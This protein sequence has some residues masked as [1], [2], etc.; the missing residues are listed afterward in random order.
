MTDG[1]P[2]TEPRRALGRGG[3]PPWWTGSASGLAWPSSLVVAVIQQ[4]GT[5]AAAQNQIGH[6]VELDLLARL[7]LLCGPAFL[8]VR[9]R[10]PRLALCG[11]A[12][13]LMV[14]LAGGYPY[15]PIFLSVV[16]ACFQALVSGH[17]RVVWGVLGA[18][19]TLHLLMGHVFYRW[20]PPGGDG[21]AGWGQELVLA[22]WV[23]AVVAVSELVRS[24]RAQWARERRE[25]QEAE[26]RRA[27]EERLRIA[28]ELHDVLAH[29]LSVIN[30]QAGVGLAL[31]DQD[32]EQARTAL[33]TIK[34]SSKEAL[35]EVRQVLERLRGHGDT[36]APRSPA[37]GVSRLPELVRQAAGAGLG[38]E[39]TSEGERTALPPGADLAVF[40]VVQEALTNVLRHSASR[41]ARVLLRYESSALEVLVDDDGPASER[42]P[43]GGGDGLVG[44][45]ERASALGGT[46]EAG[47]RADGGFRV[48]VR[49]PVRRTDTVG[50]VWREER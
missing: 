1:Q 35:G 12:A 42:G 36:R 47:P 22:G 29:S 24:R 39:V 41:R 5:T 11:T 25:R 34:G 17:R 16:L 49:L 23:V 45:R 2:L 10:Y 26:R 33:T 18:C 50:E 20:L 37:P 46:V 27:D 19:W 6:R 15:G 8:V 4:V 48:R 9:R 30:V 7:L 21:P 28:R 43:S 40:R 31:L 13:A 32:P 44:M 14:Y 38:V 3:S